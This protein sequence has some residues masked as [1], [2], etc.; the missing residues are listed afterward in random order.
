MPYRTRPRYQ[1]MT[2]HS[3]RESPSTPKPEGRP[4]PPSVLA[5]LNDMH[6]APQD[7]LWKEAAA[8]QGRQGGG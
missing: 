5:A 1:A 8:Q 3:Q 6:N 4:E 2:L 7:K